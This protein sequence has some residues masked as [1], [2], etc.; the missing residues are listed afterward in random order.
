M[1]LS[2][3]SS[4]KS[5]RMAL[6]GDQIGT[7]G[8]S[9]GTFVMVDCNLLSLERN[10]AKHLVGIL[11]EVHVGV[12]PA[13]RRPHNVALCI[14][15]HHDVGPPRPSLRIKSQ[16]F[17]HFCQEFGTGTAREPAPTYPY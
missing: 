13:L 2:G 1:S 15:H 5:G 14:A 3:W 7:L 8:M 4:R 9:N 10:K 17:W 6:R 11:G 12:L 16:D